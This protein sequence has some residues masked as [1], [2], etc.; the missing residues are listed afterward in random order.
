[1]DVSQRLFQFS[2]FSYLQTQY[3][4]HCHMYVIQFTNID[5]KYLIKPNVAYCALK[6]TSTNSMW[7]DICINTLDTYAN[8]HPHIFIYP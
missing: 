3:V 6:I 8:A 7:I 4:I 2:V 5:S 1:M